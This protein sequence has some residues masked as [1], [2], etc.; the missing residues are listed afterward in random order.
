MWP[1]H[2]WRGES[3]PFRSTS[4]TIWQWNGS[5]AS[6]HEKAKAA[7]MCRLLQEEA[8]GKV[9]EIKVLDE[10]TPEGD[11]VSKEFKY[12]SAH[13]F[14]SHLPGER[15]FLGLK[16][17]SITI[18]DAAKGGDD[19]R[20]KAFVPSV[21]YA[22]AKDS[23]EPRLSCAWKGERPP[24]SRLKTDKVCFF[25]TGFQC[26]IWAGRAAPRQDRTSAFTFAQYYL[27]RYNRPSV[28]PIT[29]FNEGLESEAFRSQFGPPEP[30]GCCVVL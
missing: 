23:G 27:K 18:K 25:D 20:V 16:V 30:P 19:E 5:E 29:R 22:G 4:D 12:R 26:Y 10:G 9:R 1:S 3:C 24:I 13:P 17:A 21:F 14:W 28:L 11:G 7:E 8:P 15:R 2:V 6:A